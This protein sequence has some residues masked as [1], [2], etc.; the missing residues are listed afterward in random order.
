[1]ADPWELTIA[2][3]VT[4]PIDAAL[5]RFVVLGKSGAGKSNANVVMAEEFI[6]SGIPTW[7]LDPLGNLWGLRS[8][9][10]TRDKVDP[11]RW[12]S[13]EFKDRDPSL[14]RRVANTRR[15]AAPDRMF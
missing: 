9:L 7:L 10:Q 1:M 11:R 12:R 8:S 4:L 13:R 15:A 2:D 3:G 14:P 5:A 6:R